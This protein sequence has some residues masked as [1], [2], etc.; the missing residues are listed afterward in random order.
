MATAAIDVS[1]GCLQ[2]LGH[3]CEASHVGATIRADALPTFAEHASTCAALGLDPLELAL[4]GGEDYEL[5]FTAPASS[6]A[7]AVGTHIGE[8]VEGADVDVVDASGRTLELARAGF[9]HFS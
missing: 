6:D 5:L 9:R 4:A 1:D 2:D 3:V 7:E 8:I